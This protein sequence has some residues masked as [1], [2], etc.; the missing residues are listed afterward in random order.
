MKYEACD[1]DGIYTAI[2][3]ISKNQTVKA[4]DQDYINKDKKKNNDEW[5]LAAYGI[6]TSLSLGFS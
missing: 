6:A 5:A 4:V 2:N 3:Q 1:T